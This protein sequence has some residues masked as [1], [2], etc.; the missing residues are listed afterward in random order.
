MQLILSKLSEKV[1]TENYWAQAIS[2]LLKQKNSLKVPADVQ[3]S[4]NNETIET[5]YRDMIMQ[6]TRSSQTK[7]NK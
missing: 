1:I 4:K 2:Q 6:T 7:N 3:M 5:V